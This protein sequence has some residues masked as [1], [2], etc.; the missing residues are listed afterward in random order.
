MSPVLE[1]QPPESRA[2]RLERLAESAREPLDVLVVGG[3]I[4]G[5]G[6]LLDLCARGL[7]VALVEQGDFAGQTSSASS[8]LIHGGL[9]YLE[10]YAFGLVRESCLERAWLLKHAAGL[11]WPESFA[12]PLE[13]GGRVGRLKLAAGLA[14]YTGLSLPRPLGLPGLISAGQLRERLPAL[15]A[16]GQARSRG[17]G[18][19]LDGATIDSRLCWAVLRSAMDRGAVA[20]S[21]LRLESVGLGNKGVLARLKGSLNSSE[22]LE[23]HASR[24][25]LCGGPFSEDL[26]GKAGLQG[27]W[28]APTRGIHVVLERQRLPSEGAVIFTSKVDGRAM[29]LIP[30]AQRTI[31]GTTDVDADPNK[32][33][34]ATLEEVDYL[35]AS[36]N[37][38]CPE[39]R[40]GRQDV[41]STWAGLRPLLASDGS[42]S[43]R[44]REERL[45]M[46]GPVY[47]LAG[48]KLTGFRSMAEGLGARLAAD[49]GRGDRRRNSPTRQIRLYGCLEQPVGRPAWSRW[50]GFGGR[51]PDA[52]DLWTWALERR[53]GAQAEFVRSNAAGTPALDP[54]TRAGEIAYAV[55][56]EDCLTAEDFLVRRTDLGYQ[57]LEALDR[58]LPEVFE[59][60]GRA[61]AWGP[62]E[63]ARE[64]Q[65]VGAL[66]QR[67]HGWRDGPR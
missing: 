25:V 43:A 30:W 67:L 42:P 6:V 26:R 59:G 23:V 63:L 33:V 3:G 50:P 5:A 18:V 52:E 40:L 41:L 62:A 27:A 65:A 37:G 22:V 39:A 61:L 17:A 7:R 60:L 13:R 29:F 36:A 66:L 9:R 57:S 64:Q 58:V 10:Q 47:T 35:L 38:L 24:L 19:Y 12:F 15:G 55:E 34:A 4:T 20:L 28:M 32:P 53:Y 56:H 45:A 1:P 8:R 48:G 46:E 21:R 49:L 11:V 31:I 54:E 44:S 2:R 51:A 14:L 16:E